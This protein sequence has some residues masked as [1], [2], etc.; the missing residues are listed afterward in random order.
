VRINGR[1]DTCVEVAKEG[2]PAV[3]MDLEWLSLPEVRKLI[4]LYKWV[5][6]S[7][8]RYTIYYGEGAMFNAAVIVVEDTGTAEKV[9][10]TRRISLV[11]RMRG[12]VGL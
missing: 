3:M 7:N 4:P 5:A 11:D 2:T 1:C 8:A 9:V 12:M 10:H 6:E